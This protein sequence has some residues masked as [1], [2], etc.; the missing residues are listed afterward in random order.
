MDDRLLSPGDLAEMMQV[1]ISTIYKWNHMGTG[2][3]VRQSASTSA[4]AVRRRRLGRGPVP[5]R[6]G[7]D[8]TG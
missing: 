3:T 1:P 2:P 5:S 7:W 8:D 6:V 4:T